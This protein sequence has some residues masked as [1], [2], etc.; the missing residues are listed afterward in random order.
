MYGCV[1]SKCV[2]RS[3]R[4]MHEVKRAAEYGVQVNGEVKSDFAFVMQRMRRIRAGISPHDS[5]WR[6]KKLG[7]DMF[8]G[9]S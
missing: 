2:I 1:P 8:S 9:S 5:V 3:G 7:I 6:M 4:A